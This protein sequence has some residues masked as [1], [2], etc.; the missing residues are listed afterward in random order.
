MG[1]GLWERSGGM[2][3]SIGVA[4][5]DFFIY[6]SSL[7]KGHP[8]TATQSRR[9][10]QLRQARERFLHGMSWKNTRN[11]QT[12]PPAP[13]PSWLI[14]LIIKYK[15]GWGGEF[16]PHLPTASC[17]HEKSLFFPCKTHSGWKR[18]ASALDKSSLRL[19]TF[20][21]N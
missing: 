19:I 1:F 8:G 12:P 13:P 4:E 5:F 20:Y 10:L 14:I 3:R 16:V 11:V 6:F 21:K 2:G 18:R 9:V 17:F 7:L 15:G